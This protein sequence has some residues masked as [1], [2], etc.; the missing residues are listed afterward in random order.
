MDEDIVQELRAW[1][2]IVNGVQGKATIM[3]LSG[4]IFA[5]AADEIERLRGEKKS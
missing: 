1:A 2:Y 3:M 4:D 5:E